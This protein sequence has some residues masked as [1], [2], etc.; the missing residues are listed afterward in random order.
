MSKAMGAF[1]IALSAINFGV[2]IWEAVIAA[3]NNPKYNDYNGDMIQ[4]Y[5]FCVIKCVLNIIFGF[6]GI[7]NGLVIC[8]VLEKDNGNYKKTINQIRLLV[9]FVVDIWGI[10]MYFDNYKLGPFHKVV[11]AETIIFFAAI[12]LIGLLISLMYKKYIEQSNQHHT[13]IDINEHLKQTLVHT[14][15][16]PYSDAINVYLL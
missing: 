8:C 12:G 13:N 4:G 9:D 16:T 10:I 1:I 2:G 11:F 5:A 6:L 14:D 3:S 7:L 15:I